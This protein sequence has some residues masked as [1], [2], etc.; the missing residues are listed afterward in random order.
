MNESQFYLARVHINKGHHTKAL[1]ILEKLYEKQPEQTRYAFHLAKYYNA[2]GRISDCRKVVKGILKREKKEYPQLDLLQGTLSLAE[3]RYDKA[4]LFLFKA[5]QA[6]PRLPT[7]HKQ[8][9]K[10]YLKMRRMKDAE[11][12]FLKALSIDPDSAI[13]YRGLA[14]MKEQLKLLRFA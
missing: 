7:L 6:D 13:A 5:E 1:P 14:S 4:L 2:L 12:T 8:I 11:R 3:G 10:V 9:G